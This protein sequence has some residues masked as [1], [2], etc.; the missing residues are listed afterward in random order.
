MGLDNDNPNP[1]LP[2]RVWYMPGT[3]DTKIA[4]ICNLTGSQIKIDSLGREIFPGGG[5]RNK[6]FLRPEMAQVPL[7]PGL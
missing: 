4:S 7:R 6:H 3:V 1:M 2:P 5:A